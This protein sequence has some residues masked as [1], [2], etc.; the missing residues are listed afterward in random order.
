[1]GFR[2]LTQNDPPFRINFQ[3]LARAKQSHGKYAVLLGVRG[4]LTEKIMDFLPKGMTAA[5]QYIVC[6]ERRM[7]IKSLVPITG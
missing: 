1:M 5:V 4:M 7:N 6:L 2:G 3:I